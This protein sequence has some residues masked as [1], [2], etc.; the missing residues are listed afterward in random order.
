MTKRS[1]GRRA[2]VVAVSGLLWASAAGCSGGG[3]DNT[4]PPSH[5]ADASVDGT[6][7]N[8]DTGADSESAPDG[9]T[10]NPDAGGTPGEDAGDGSASS[11]TLSFALTLPG[12]AVVSGVTYHLVDSSDTT[13]ALQA[14]PD[15]GTANVSDDAFQ[16]GGVPVATGD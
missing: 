11:G 16:L 1:F 13:V 2:P 8:P 12:G 7:G 5:P 4:V 14:A 6:T 15:P 10:Q 3:D 9:S